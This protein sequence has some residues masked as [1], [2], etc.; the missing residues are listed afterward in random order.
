VVA[1]A[2]VL[3]LLCSRQTVF[4]VAV[5]VTLCKVLPLQKGS[6]VNQLHCQSSLLLQRWL[7]TSVLLLLLFVCLLVL[8][9][10][11]CLHW[12]NQII[13]C[14][15]LVEKSEYPCAEDVISGLSMV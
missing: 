9:L 14:I 13:V 2:R 1:A 3:L 10:F 4:V 5:A 7:T 8:L 6:E 12:D 15:F 11:C